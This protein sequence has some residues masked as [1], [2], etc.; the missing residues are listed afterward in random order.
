MLLL[1]LVLSMPKVNGIWRSVSIPK[2][3]FRRILAVL[4][5]S[6]ALTVA[7]YVR[8]AIAERL[9]YDE[10]HTE[11]QKMKEEEIKERLQD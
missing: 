6:E 7:E 10:I 1:R 8:F 4:G 9:K 11:E 2:K 3:V 5:Y